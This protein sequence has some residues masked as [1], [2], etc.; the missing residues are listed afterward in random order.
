M[1]KSLVEDPKCIA[2]YYRIPLILNAN[3]EIA[4]DFK[5]F[6]QNKNELT[7]TVDSKEVKILIFSLPPHKL[8]FKSLLKTLAGARGSLILNVFNHKNI[9]PIIIKSLEVLSMSV[10]MANTLQI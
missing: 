4:V 6:K 8:E 3:S 10:C 9:F 1:I 5:K 7:S 2:M